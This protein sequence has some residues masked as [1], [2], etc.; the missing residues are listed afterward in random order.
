MLV[1]KHCCFQFF[2]I[3]S[4]DVNAAQIWHELFKTTYSPNIRLFTIDPNSHD[5]V[6]FWT[7][8]SRN[9]QTP[10][11]GQCWF[12]GLLQGRGW[13]HSRAQA[14]IVFCTPWKL[15]V[16]DNMITLKSVLPHCFICVSENHSTNHKARY[17]SKTVSNY[18]NPWEKRLSISMQWWHIILSLIL[19]ISLFW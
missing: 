18:R 10:L 14:W 5:L 8:F 4:C 15:R 1:K 11:I 9:S 6:G 3:Y 16:K 13:T 7:R 19:P 2:C 12:Q 17:K